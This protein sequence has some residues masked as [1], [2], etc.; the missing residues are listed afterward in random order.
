MHMAGSLGLGTGR[1]AHCS[2]TI[3]GT[4]LFVSGRVKTDDTGC[5]TQQAKKDFQACLLHSFEEPTRSC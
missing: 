4:A 3:K 1:T 2:P 5:R